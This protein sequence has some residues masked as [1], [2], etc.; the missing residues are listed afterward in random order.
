[1]PIVSWNS[2]FSVGVYL[3]DSEHKQLLEL[4]N[5]FYDAVLARMDAH[6]IL[7]ILDSLI[8]F[9]ESHFAHEEEFFD[10]CRYGG[11]DLHKAEHRRLSQELQQLRGIGVCGDIRPLVYD[12]N[13]FLVRWFTV[14]TDGPDREFCSELRK[15]GIR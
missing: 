8:R 13:A 7:T 9:A 12:L 6:E 4:V 11:A 15:L 2:R 14:H 10:A 3:F 1:M 5:D